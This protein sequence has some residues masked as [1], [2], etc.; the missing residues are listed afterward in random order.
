MAKEQIEYGQKFRELQRAF[1]HITTVRKPGTTNRVISS[2][3]GWHGPANGT[4]QQ[5]AKLSMEGRHSKESVSDL[6]DLVAGMAAGGIEVQ[7]GQ[8]V[9]YPDRF[10]TKNAKGDD[11][12]YHSGE[13][14]NFPR[15]FYLNNKHFAKMRR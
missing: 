2:V 14:D 4:D 5:K 6:F 11:V 7:K 13:D 15:G 9:A 10:V 12:T 3:E 1:G 8:T